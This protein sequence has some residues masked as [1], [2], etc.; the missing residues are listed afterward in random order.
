MNVTL[1][2]PLLGAPT[3]PGLKDVIDA[4]KHVN[5]ESLK[6]EFDSK[7]FGLKNR[8]AGETYK[9]LASATLHHRG[10]IKDKPYFEVPIDGLR[11]AYFDFAKQIDDTRVGVH[12]GFGH[13]SGITGVAL[14][15][16]L[17]AHATPERPWHPDFHVI[18]VG[19]SQFNVDL[20]I[21]GASA[22]SEQYSAVLKLLGHSLPCTTVL[23]SLT[24]SGTFRVVARK[25]PP[26]STQFLID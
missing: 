12:W 5:A 10:W 25:G 6:A 4:L 26:Q 16:L 13:A 19:D 3:I 2:G 17:T 11:A 23:I 24:S 14:S 22:T 20:H 9:K 8:G 15:P 18:I 21:N 1:F 7:A